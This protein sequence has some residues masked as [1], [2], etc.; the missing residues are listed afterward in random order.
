MIIPH[1]AAKRKRIGG[2]FVVI[3]FGY[4]FDTFFGVFL[5]MLRKDSSDTKPCASV[6]INQ[7][8][9]YFF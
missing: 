2:Y 6:K 5:K 7:D 1:V 3:F 8:Q 4:F 9:G